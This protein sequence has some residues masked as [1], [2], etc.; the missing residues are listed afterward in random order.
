MAIQKKVK[1]GVL[2]P[3]EWEEADRIFRL[4]F[5]TFLG[6]PD[7]SSFMG[8]RQKVLPR[9]R[10]A[11]VKALAARD[12]G[13]LI[14]ANFITRW[15]SFAFF[16]PL[17][18]L[19]EYWNQGVAQQLLQT[20]IKTIDR[21]GSRR[22]GLLTFPHST[23]HVALYQKFGFWPQYLTALMVYE[24]ALHCGGAI[25]LLSE[26]TG[27]ERDKAVKKCSALAKQVANGLD[28][29]EEIRSVLK[30]KVGEVLLV[31]T[32]GLL[33][34]FAICLSGAGTE[35]GTGLCYVKLGAVR[36]GAG[37]EGR[38]SR[39]LDSCEAFAAGRGAKIEAGMNLARVGAYKAMRARGYQVKAQGVAMQRPNKEGHNRADCWIIDD[40]R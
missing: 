21:W 38:F 19:P 2:R 17:C 37:A 9:M 29:A 12:N 5:G 15:G 25:A 20:T 32:R 6:L 14:G 16:G 27:A 3:N 36:S 10:S 34:G 7:P 33:D 35:G 18:V 39:L 24:P 30:Q 13:R 11:H 26:R 22:T 4:A 31:E 28:P 40:W 8:D 23:K 1:V